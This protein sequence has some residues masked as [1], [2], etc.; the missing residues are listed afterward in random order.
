MKVS[1][2]QSPSLARNTDSVSIQNFVGTGLE[3]CANGS[4]HYETRNKNIFTSLC[5]VYHKQ[6]GTNIYGFVDSQ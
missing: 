4:K 1:V 5:L 6:C 2:R 3:T